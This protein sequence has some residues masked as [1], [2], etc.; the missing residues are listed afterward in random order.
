MLVLYFYIKYI[1]TENI[2]NP[3]ATYFLFLLSWY[4]LDVVYH[5]STMFS[6]YGKLACASFF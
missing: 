2:T 1:Q 3:F 4:F 5:F 6:A